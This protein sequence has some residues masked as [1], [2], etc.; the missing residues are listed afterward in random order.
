[1]VLEDNQ[2]D[3]KTKLQDERSTGPTKH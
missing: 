3:A 2:V 1:V